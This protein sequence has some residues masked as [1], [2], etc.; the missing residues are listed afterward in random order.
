MP[1]EL[2]NVKT[3]VAFVFEKRKQLTGYLDDGKISW[4]ESV[5][6]AA[7]AT[8][9][10]PLIKETLPNLGLKKLTAAQVK[11][12]VEHVATQF[13]LVKNKALEAQIKKTIT[14]VYSTQELIAGW[15]TI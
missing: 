9:T 10:V 8:E 15:K 6:I 12:I 2:K 4:F 5:G 11:E 7:M 13:N 1:T 14:W 3:L